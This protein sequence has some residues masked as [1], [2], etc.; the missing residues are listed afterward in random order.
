MLLKS[1]E[2][3]KQYEQ[4]KTDFAAEED[5]DDQ[6]FSYQSGSAFHYYPHGRSS[7]SGHQKLRQEGY[8]DLDGSPELVIKGG[9]KRKESKK[10]GGGGGGG[11]S[12]AR[13]SIHHSAHGYGQL[14]EEEDVIFEL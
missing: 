3:V 2:D 14:D 8:T 6:S 11:A 7:R 1:K 4:R 10:G 13:R 9:A 5:D 12:G